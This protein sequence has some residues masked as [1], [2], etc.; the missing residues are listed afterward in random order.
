MVELS[1]AFFSRGRPRTFCRGWAA[2]QADRGRR[3]FKVVLKV[4]TFFQDLVSVVQ[5]L[6]VSSRDQNLV[7]VS[8]ILFPVATHPP[9]RRPPPH[10]SR[11]SLALSS[12]VFITSVRTLKPP[13]AFNHQPPSSRLPSAISL[14]VSPTC[15][16]SSSTHHLTFASPCSYCCCCLLHLYLR[17]QASCGQLATVAANFTPTPCKVHCRCSVRSAT[18]V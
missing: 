7:A 4:V 1:F 18:A 16:G 5:R 14:Q 10:G 12:S 6:E 8:S 2:H 9:R 3:E 13:P 17:P 11:C 15:S